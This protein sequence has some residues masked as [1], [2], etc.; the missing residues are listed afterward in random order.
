LR[1]RS[2][3]V[4]AQAPEEQLGLILAPARDR[5]PAQQHDAGALLQ[6][7]R[8]IE[9]PATQRR[10]WKVATPQRR[11]RPTRALGEHHRAIDLLD[12]ARIELHAPVRARLELVA[13]PS[14]GSTDRRARDPGVWPREVVQRLLDDRS[15]LG[16]AT[17][18]MK[19][20]Q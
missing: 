3:E 9:D 6:L 12:V 18:P 5:E 15:N 13:T 1:A 17:T 14:R 8:P 7:G 4:Q 19:S 20:G 16:H 10:Q 2:T 11:E